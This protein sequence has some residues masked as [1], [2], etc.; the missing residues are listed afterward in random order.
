M[1]GNF[2]VREGSQNGTVEEGYD[3]NQA[4]NG[5]YF[6]VRPDASQVEMRVQYE[7]K[8][9]GRFTHRISPTGKLR[10]VKANFLV[11]LITHYGGRKHTKG[12]R[13][14]QDMNLRSLGGVFQELPEF[15]ETLVRFLNDVYTPAKK[16]D[17]VPKMYKDFIIETWEKYMDEVSFRHILKCAQ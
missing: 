15:P 8:D 17:P 6:A 1:R 12:G 14:F 13:E 11:E 7:G 10:L 3:K 9:I 4:P 16:T 2:A 5:K